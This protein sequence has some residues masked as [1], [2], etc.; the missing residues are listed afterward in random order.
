M[1]DYIYRSSFRTEVSF[2]SWRNALSSFISK[3]TEVGND[4]EGTH[5][6]LIKEG[7]MT[8]IPYQ[9]KKF[10]QARNRAIVHKILAF[11]RPKSCTCKLAS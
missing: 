4:A 7:E 1:L 6:T 10:V 5:L 2:L 9:W 3:E 11:R 8:Y